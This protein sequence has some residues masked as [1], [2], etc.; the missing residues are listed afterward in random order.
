MHYCEQYGMVVNKKTK[1]IGISSAPCNKH[2]I[3]Y[4]G[5]YGHVEHKY[6]D[7]YTY[8]GSPVTSAASE[9]HRNKFIMFKNR[10]D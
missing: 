1:F 6:S 7:N 2:S 9:K 3:Q 8:L 10:Y 5:P 4:D